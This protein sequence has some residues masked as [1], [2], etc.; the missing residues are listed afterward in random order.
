MLFVYIKLAMWLY[1]RE[2]VSVNVESSPTDPAVPLFQAWHVYVYV[3]VLSQ[4]PFRHEETSTAP[5][6]IFSYGG[7]FACFPFGTSSAFHNLH[8]PEWGYGLAR[9]LHSLCE[10]VGCKEIFDLFV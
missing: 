4:R 5:R 8:S 2:C 3:Y 7:F 10:S 9:L 1:A 6:Q